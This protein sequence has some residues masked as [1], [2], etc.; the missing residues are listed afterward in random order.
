MILLLFPLR[1][2]C[3]KEDVY[4]SNLIKNTLFSIKN[5]IFGCCKITIWDSPMGAIFKFRS[6]KSHYRRYWTANSIGA[7][8]A[9]RIK[10]S[11]VYDAFPR[12]YTRWM[13]FR[14]CHCCR[15]KIGKS[16]CLRIFP[17]V[18]AFPREV[19]SFNCTIKC[20]SFPKMHARS[21]L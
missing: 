12:V 14:T 17:M 11:T 19:S 2:K 1:W 6:E 4:F 21:L 5:G 9:S 15:G 20:S 10:L 7:E 13:N 18:Y 8:F 16:L 3:W